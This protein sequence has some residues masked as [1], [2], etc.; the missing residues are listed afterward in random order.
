MIV[1]KII[2]YIRTI[3]TLFYYKAIYRS[4][5]SYGKNLHLENHLC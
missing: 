5:F 4:K 2:N 1:I 3:I